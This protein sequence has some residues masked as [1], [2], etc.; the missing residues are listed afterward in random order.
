MNRLKTQLTLTYVIIS[1]I[2][3]ALISVLA[4][5]MVDKV[6]SAYI[7]NVREN[8]SAE[9]VTQLS[10]RYNSFTGGW[11]YD[12]LESIGAG[13]LG[14]G[15]IIIIKANNGTVLWNAWEHNGGECSSMLQKLSE[16][17]Y[18]RYR[19]FYGAYV[20][21]S[22]EITVMDALAGYVVI[23]YYG[24]YYYTDN[25]LAFINAF[26]T[27]LTGVGAASL[28]IAVILGLFTSSW[29]S[30]PIS[31][32]VH[33]TEQIA[34]GN[35]RERVLV[36]SPTKEINEMAAAINHLAESLENVENLRKRLTGD[37]AHELRTPLFTLQ[38]HIEAMLDGIWE[39]DRARLASCH[40]E[41]VR[42][43]RMVGD[44]KKLADFESENLTLD[45]TWFSLNELLQNIILN[46]E[47]EFIAKDITL[48]FN[49][50]YNV[51]IYADKDKINQIFVNLISNALNYTEQN[52]SVEIN[53]SASGGEAVVSVRDTG[54]GI[55]KGELPYIFERFYRTDK[56][57]AKS[58]G[59][60]GIGLTIAKSLVLAH[61]GGITVESEPGKGTEF[62]VSL[63]EINIK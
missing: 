48:S 43:N 27:M 12:T 29:L 57:R 4:N 36:K 31:K 60:S 28:V 24:P 35:L 61:E 30:K 39:P 25:D 10:E 14:N 33:F 52:G 41:T 45:K 6:F 1:V 62:T 46:F 17:M 42:L 23:G 56:S 47:A 16:N 54:I 38:S 59:G 3:V 8:K 15:L 18:S 44:L 22:Y 53:V 58:T 20:E 32:V 11:R 55:P 51:Q 26:N 50:G 2:I 9:I 40:D 63:P 21:D 49:T 19:S 34:G 13:A 37:I 7:K 5:F